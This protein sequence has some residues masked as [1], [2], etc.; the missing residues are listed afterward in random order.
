MLPADLVA[1]WIAHWHVFADY[2]D[3]PAVRSIVVSYSTNIL[4]NV[5]TAMIA[6]RLLAAVAL[7]RERIRR[8]RAGPDVLHHAPALHPEHDG[9]QL[10]HAADAGRIFLPVRVAAHRKRARAV[11]R[12]HGARTKS[13]DSPDH[14]ARPDG[15]G[16]F[17]AGR[18][19][20]R[21]GARPRIVAA[22]LDTARSPRPSTLFF[23]WSIA[24]YQFLPL[25]IIHQY[26]RSIFAKE[27][28]L[29]D[30]TLPAN[31]PW[32]TPFHE[33]FLGAFFKPEKSIFLFDPFSCSLS[34]SS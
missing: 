29:Q 7:R 19:L 2:E 1:T 33:G 17:S 20:V 24:G 21:A 16:D 31:F 11:H 27:Q 28:R 4:V 10:H 26:L 34:F 22:L 30:P 32:S 13:A 12:L 6:F 3:D 15:G 23:C 25:R 8:R 18:A 9:E 5:L 14:R